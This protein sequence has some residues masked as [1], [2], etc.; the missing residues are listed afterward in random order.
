MTYTVFTLY[1]S[2]LRLPVGP[3][4]FRNSLDESGTAIVPTH[5]NRPSPTMPPEQEY[6]VMREYTD[7]LPE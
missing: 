2:A 4:Q 1:A 7:V 3:A 5:W 6:D